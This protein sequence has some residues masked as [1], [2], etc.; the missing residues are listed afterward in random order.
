MLLNNF[1]QFGKWQELLSKSSKW[2]NNYFIQKADT[3]CTI[4]L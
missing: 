2:N 1:W 4:P 3:S